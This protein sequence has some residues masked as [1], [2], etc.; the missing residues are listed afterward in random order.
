MSIHVALLEQHR[1][2]CRFWG[3]LT[4]LSA[5]ATVVLMLTAF[6]AFLHGNIMVAIP[7]MTIAVLIGHAGNTAERLYA[8]VSAK[9]NY[10]ELLVAHQ[11]HMQKM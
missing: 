5:F 2:A 6:W 8:D 4:L 3:V 11:Q 10:F 9:A 1:R 7:S